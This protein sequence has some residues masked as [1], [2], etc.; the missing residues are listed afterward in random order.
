M[1]S[2]MAWTVTLIVDP[3]PFRPGP[4]MLL[5][6]LGLASGATVAT[7]GM[8]VVGGRWAHRYASVTLAG[9]AAVAM[10]RPIDTAWWASAVVTTLSGIALVVLADRVR[11][12]PSATGPP[13]RAV[14][15]PLVLLAA[16]L[17]LGLA[18]P[19]R[20]WPVLIVGL[21]A[22][23]AALAYARVMFGGLVATRILFPVAAV[24]LALLMEPAVG[25]V[26]GL[27]GGTTAALA[28]HPSVKTAYHPPRERGSL[29]PIPPEL[30][31]DEVLDAARIDDT[32][33]PR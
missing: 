9:G 11:R 22:P 7:V 32:G 4:S 26:S 31:P 28:W 2:A 5:V 1:A 33:R 6:A 20:W 13:T 25:A 3:G 29:F 15:V 8:V 23:V 16:P 14:L 17:A 10:I 18:T 21:G 30:T 19:T 27:L 12:L 24:G